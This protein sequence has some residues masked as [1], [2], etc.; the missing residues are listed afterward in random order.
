MI[1]TPE[2][3]SK[4]IVTHLRLLDPDLSA[5]IGS[6]ERKLIDAVAAVIS[7]S[8]IQSQLT[9]SI[10]DIDT[11]GGIELEEIVGLFGFGRR[12]GAKANGKLV[13]QLDSPAPQDYILPAGTRAATL[14][15]QTR[16]SV[17]YATTAPV[18]IT[19]GTTYAEVPAECTET[20]E[21][22]NTAAAT[23]V[24]LEN[25][26]SVATVVN[27]APF[28]N[29]RDAETD[30]QLRK[31]FKMTFLRNLAGTEDFYAALCLNHVNVSKV[32]VIGPVERN[33]E[34]LQ[35]ILENGLLTMQSAISY[36]KFAY[37]QGTIIYKDEDTYYTEGLQYTVN[38]STPQIIV[39]CEIVQNDPDD[40]FI[41]DGDIVTVEH[42]YCSTASRNNPVNGITNCVDI[43]VNGA[44]ATLTSEHSLVRLRQLNDPFL[45]GRTF[46][47][48]D[49]SIMSTGRMQILGYG[50]VVALPSS[51]TIGNT[52]YLNKTVDKSNDY[53]LVREI[54]PLAGSA[55]AVYGV[56]FTGTKY[57]SQGEMLTIDYTYN[58]VPLVLDEML[59]LNKQITTDIMV[60]EAEIVPLGINAIIQ[61]A[62]GFSESTVRNEITENLTAWVN[63]LGYGEWIQFSDIH[64]V[65]RQSDGVDNARMK[66]PSDT[67]VSTA[68]GIQQFSR[69]GYTVIST[70][71]GD[72]RLKDSQLASLRSVN[73]VMKAENTFGGA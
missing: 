7:S 11:K 64:D 66:L 57:P 20:G 68:F 22:G 53:R 8:Y 63:G 15:T 14:E 19:M 49:G 37:P 47:D 55:S 4:D 50:P 43:Y 52:T 62:A 40:F 31:R 9:S 45:K 73:I 29:G 24:V 12:T 6:P 25:W 26:T 54:G 44:E 30:D 16:P 27:P 36:S 42:E 41:H 32:R 18:V 61:L 34:Q 60:H 46:Q 56:L 13:I 35:A 3:V 21:I 23:I 5:Q 72:F 59:E 48:D 33:V 65:I 10:W 1:R 58:R 2:A 51:L 67:P 38:T 70:H 28:I 69:N 39:N 17:S 71:T